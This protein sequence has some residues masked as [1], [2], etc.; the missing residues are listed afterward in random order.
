VPPSGERSTRSGAVLVDSA[1]RLACSETP[2][3][4]ARGGRANAA[5]LTRSPQPRA[6][7]F[8]GSVRVVARPDRRASTEQGA[9]AEQL[10]PVLAR[11]GRRLHL[12]AQGSGRRGRADPASSRWSRWRW[13][14]VLPLLPWVLAITRAVVGTTE[15]RLGGHGEYCRPVD[16]R[17]SRNCWAD[18][19]RTYTTARAGRG[20]TAEAFAGRGSVRGQGLLYDGA[21]PVRAAG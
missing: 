8:V 16:S 20:A 4:T 10:V 18:D 13:S 7:A 6:E 11:A 2:A 12:G 3:A 14:A 9:Q 5:S 21:T 15:R 19:W 17:F 1:P